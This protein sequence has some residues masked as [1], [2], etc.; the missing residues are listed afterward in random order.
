VDDEPNILSA[1]RRLLRREGYQLHLAPGG[2]E[3][4]QILAEHHVDLVITDSRMPG[5]S[6]TELLKQVKAEY[7]DTIRMILSGYTGVSELADALNEGEAYRFI[8]KPWNDEELKLTIRHALEHHR[9]MKENRQL[10][11]KIKAQNE[12][13]KTL[14]ATLEE[15][16][17]MKTRELRLHNRA[18]M[19]AQEIL[20]QLPGPLIGID[21]TGTIVHANVLGVKHFLAE[22][23]TV[24]SPM[25]SC[26]PEAHQQAV[27]KTIATGTAHTVE[28]AS[29]SDG[30][31]VCY[32]LV[33]EGGQTRGA[34]LISSTMETRGDG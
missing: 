17:E 3:A 4:M 1:L 26:L 31:F 27:R 20:D 30:C 18:L 21:T 34:V 2:A 28:S 33:R 13:L 24:G 16:V 22:G 15:A 12:E 29:D 14:N 23:A 19:L 7:P 10:V 25:E 8:L 11:E 9:V 32:P 6:G 5:M